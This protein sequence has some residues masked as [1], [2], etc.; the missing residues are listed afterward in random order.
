MKEGQSIDPDEAGGRRVGIA[1][2]QNRAMSGDDVAHHRKIDKG[3]V[4][5]N[6]GVA[7]IVA[8]GDSRAEQR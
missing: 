5:W 6:D 1:W 2:I 3:V 8:D 7:P 4:I